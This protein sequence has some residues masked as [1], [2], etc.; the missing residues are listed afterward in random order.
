MDLG[1]K[2]KR[3]LVTG[4]TA[5]IGL[6]TAI[7]LAAEG[8]QVI[9]NGRTRT[10]VAAALAEVKRKVPDA[11]VMGIPADL[12]TR[13]GC[14]H[15]D[16]AVA[17]RR[18]AGQQRRHLR[19]EAVRGDPRRG[20]AAILRDQRAERRPARA[21][22]R[23]RACARETGGASC[24][25]RANRA[26]Q[27]PVE[28][29]HYGMTKTAQLAV[30]RGLAEIAGRHRR[31][32]EQRAARPDGVRGRG[33]RSWPAWRRRAVSMRQRSSASFSHR[34]AVVDRQALRH[35]RE[36]AAMIAY[37]CSVPASATTG[38]ALRVDGG[39]VRSIA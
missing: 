31:H 17:G 34:A 27:I 10:R 32:R 3:V 38:A 9:V 23:A 25:S 5:G 13:A 26:L 2:N 19:A 39:V 29:I 33:R 4:S 37:V 18:R 16:R 11:T 28:M 36:V 1:L 14:E 15:I 7:A 24:S 12:G 20:L 6:A 35:H 22:L 8:A 21:P 30:A